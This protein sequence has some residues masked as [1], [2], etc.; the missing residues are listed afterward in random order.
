VYDQPAPLRNTLINLIFETPRFRIHIS[1]QA[2]WLENMESGHWVLRGQSTVPVASAALQAQA[3]PSLL[4][5]AVLEFEQVRAGDTNLRS[6]LTGYRAAAAVQILPR[7]TVRTF[8]QSA[9]PARS[10]SI[11]TRQPLRPPLAA[12]PSLKL[13]EPA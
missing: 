7:T 13:L 6:A 4:R 9:P 12:K 3:Q 8:L 11:W 1:G 2:A 5:D 10:R